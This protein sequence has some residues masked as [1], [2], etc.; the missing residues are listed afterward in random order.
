MGIKRLERARHDLNAG[1]GSAWDNI[2][3]TIAAY[4]LACGVDDQE[5][6]NRKRNLQAAFTLETATD[7]LTEL[8]RLMDGAAEGALSLIDELEQAFPFPPTDNGDETRHETK[9]VT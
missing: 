7:Y 1:M 8:T 2:W 6:A 3:T 5:I 9:A 4:L